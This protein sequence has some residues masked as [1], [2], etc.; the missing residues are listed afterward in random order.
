MTRDSLENAVVTDPMP[1]GLE[2]L[3]NS[4]EVKEVE[5]DISGNV[6]AEKEEEVIF[7]NKSSTNELNLEFGNT[8]KA[9]KITFKTNIKEEEKDRE[10]WALYHNTAYLDSDG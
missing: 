2:L 7:T 10:G 6:I 4:I 1:E 3:T 8:N 5:V 9:Y